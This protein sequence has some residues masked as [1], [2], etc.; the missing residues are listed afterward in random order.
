MPQQP[1]A[2]NKTDSFAA[3]SGV[4]PSLIGNSMKD[5]KRA[6]LFLWSSQQGAGIF[7]SFFF[8]SHA[9]GFRSCA[10]GFHEHEEHLA[11]LPSF[12]SLFL[13][14]FLFVFFC[15]EL[16]FQK[17]Q[18]DVEA[19]SCCIVVFVWAVSPKVEFLMIA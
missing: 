16:D 6:L 17:I 9:S 1:P 7:G 12:A 4:L 18:I 14:W 5:A 10:L 13:R 19:Q 15:F 8:G 11:S 2:S 3:L